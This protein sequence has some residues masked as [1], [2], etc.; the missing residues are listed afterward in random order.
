MERL[1]ISYG[2]WKDMPDD[3]RTRWLARDLYIERQTTDMLNSLKRG[4]KYSEFV[5]GAVIGIMAKMI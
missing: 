4:D 2:E 3:E 5:I 1:G